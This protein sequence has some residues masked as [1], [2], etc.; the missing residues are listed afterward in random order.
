VGTLKLI[1]FQRPSLSV[2]QGV[3]PDVCPLGMLPGFC[4]FTHV[5]AGVHKAPSHAIVLRDRW[6]PR[7]GFP[8][9]L[10]SFAPCLESAGRNLT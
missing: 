1:Q 6:G 2:S 9:L 10:G 7:D 8:L 3:L 4:V 5:D